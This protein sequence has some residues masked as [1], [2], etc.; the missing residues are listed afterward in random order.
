MTSLFV[1]KGLTVGCNLINFNG[2][3]YCFFLLIFIFYFILEGNITIV[4]AHSDGT[5]S[6]FRTRMF[7]VALDVMTFWFLNDIV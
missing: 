5:A 7:H 1:I 2:H 4:C 3:F 6:V